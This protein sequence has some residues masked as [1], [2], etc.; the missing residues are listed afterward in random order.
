MQKT[1]CVRFFLLLLVTALA[2]CSSV[3]P[4]HPAAT[5][6][7]VWIDVR[8]VEEYEADHIDGDRNMPVQELSSNTLRSQLNLPS[9][10]DIRLYCVSGVRAGRAK[11]IFEEAGFSNVINAGGISD[12]REA[13]NLD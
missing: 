9:D 10:A 7:T 11:L 3:M 1:F 13:R 6:E 8:T 12:A 5:A 2:S 4:E